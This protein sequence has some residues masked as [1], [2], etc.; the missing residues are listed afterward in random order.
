M[1]GRSK[2]KRTEMDAT[3]DTAALVNRSRTKLV[4]TV[5]PACDSP[6]MLARLAQ[7]GVDVFRLNMAH[8]TTDS[9]KQTLDNI[10]QL[11]ERLSRPLGVLVDLAGP[12][13]RLG[14]LIPDPF[15]C[16]EGSLLRLVPGEGSPEPG[17]LVT[18][19]APL[20]E[21]L[22]VGD[23]V[24]L[25][26][27]MISLNVVDQNAGYV[28]LEVLAGGQ[29]R[30]RQG[31]NLP[32]AKLSVAAMTEL[33]RSHAQWA[34]QQGV[35]FVGLSFVRAPEDVAQLQ[36]VLAKHKSRA[37]TIAKIEK[38][39]ALVRLDEIVQAAAGVMV[40]RGDLGVEIDVATM[41]F[42]QKQIID[43]CSRWQK[44]VIVATQMLD[45]MQH[46]RR[47]TR[48]EVTDV[49]NAVLDGAD[50]CMLSGETAIGRYPREAVEMMSRIMQTSER[51]MQHRLSQAARDPTASSVHP[52]TSA[53]VRGATE[54][55][56]QLGAKMVV[57][58]TRSGRTALVKSKLRE[59]TFTVAVSESQETLR[60][61][62]LLWGIH[63]LHAAGAYAG[64]DLRRFINRWGRETGNVAPGDR[65]VLVAGTGIVP[66]AHNQVV[67]HEVE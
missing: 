22:A 31:V 34:A 46:S 53:V 9:H 4:A 60:Q 61:M 12:K 13:I 56:R 62:S 20:V 59:F 49:A 18:S 67:V 27:G 50:A 45:S 54:I 65:I 3:V 64:P 21:E 1:I 48:A 40:A 25:A 38:P 63:P 19:Y 2:E 5:G 42:A 44:P 43:T 29:V 52:V 23:A 30:S 7:A 32:G 11:G 57:I 15:P 33:D 24:M 35:D 8:G 6:D 17:V 37:L 47:P 66:V 58:A 36:E 39:E 16:P 26:D 28:L 14:Q 41:P 10:R 51:L 55:A